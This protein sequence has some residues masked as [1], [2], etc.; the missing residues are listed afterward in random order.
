[1]RI[2]LMGPPGAGKGTQAARLATALGVPAISTGEIFRA[3]VEAQTPLGRE[4]KRYLNAG[5]YVPDNVTNGLVRERLQHSDAERGWLLDGY[6]RT[7]AQL[8]A[9]DDMTASAGQ[10]VD[11]VVA[12]DVNHELLV[13]RLTERART[14][15]RDDE[16]E[17][18]IRHRQLLYREQTSPLLAAYEARSLLSTVNG[19]GEVGEVTR[20]ILDALSSKSARPA[21]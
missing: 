19:E 17:D 5:R 4:A 9:L 3:N 21:G 8:D 15:G 18:V 2:L 11:A 20:R 14:Q 16:T 10:G 1:M 12:L 7:L 6:P 13:R